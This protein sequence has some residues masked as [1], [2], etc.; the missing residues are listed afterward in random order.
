[1]NE[2]FSTLKTDTKIHSEHPSVFVPAIRYF[3][4]RTSGHLS[5]CSEEQGRKGTHHI[6]S[7]KS[8]HLTSL[9]NR[10]IGKF[11]CLLKHSCIVK[12]LLGYRT[13]FVYL[14]PSPTNFCLN[15][16]SPKNGKEIYSITVSPLFRNRYQ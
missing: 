7:I 15:S 14:F 11:S 16:H 3:M 12:C 5:G 1:M 6:I 9:G 10:K 13:P 4:F 8:Y 2:S